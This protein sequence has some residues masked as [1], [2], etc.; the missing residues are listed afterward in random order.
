MRNPAAILAVCAAALACGGQAADPAAEHSGAERIVE[1]VDGEP[2]YSGTNTGLQLDWEE[3]DSEDIGQSAQPLL[4]A[5]TG[6]RQPGFVPGSE[7]SCV[8]TGGASQ[9]CVVPPMNGH[10]AFVYY[11]T[12]GMGPRIGGAFGV[13]RFDV[14]SQLTQ[15]YVE[16]VAQG[17]ETTGSGAIDFRETTDLND[18]ELTY[19][20]DVSDSGDFCSG[21]S[22]KGN[23]C[24]TGSTTGIAHDSSLV[25][26]YHLM[27]NVP[28]IHID[29][30]AI[31]TK[32]GWTNTQK[33]NA[34]HQA[35]VLAFLKGVGQGPKNIAGSARCDQTDV[36]TGFWCTLPTNSACKVNGWGDFGDDSFVRLLGGNCG[37]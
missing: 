16:L 15:L 8:T 30:E 9:N 14:Y 24:F 37:N 11:M 4:F 18:P 22:S 17:I 3:S 32:A 25:G 7:E 35:I 27:V 36:I 23:V 6:S 26:T 31:R 5:P 34:L 13:A 12:G 21:T 1:V 19:V 2:M 20:I 10:K 28:A 33:T 29:Y